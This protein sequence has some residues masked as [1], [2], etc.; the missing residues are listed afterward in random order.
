MRTLRL[1]GGGGAASFYEELLDFLLVLGL[2][3]LPVVGGLF[4]VALLGVE[5]FFARDEPGC[6]VFEVLFAAFEPLLELR[7]TLLKLSVMFGQLEPDRFQ[8]L[9]A[10]L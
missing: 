9:S 4:V 8:I 6:P 7:A 1:L 2:L 3:R 5:F 10:T